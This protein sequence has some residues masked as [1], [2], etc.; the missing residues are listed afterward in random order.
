MVSQVQVGRLTAEMA[1]LRPV[2]RK[3]EMM[4]QGRMKKAMKQAA[5]MIKM[6]RM[7]REVEIR[8]MKTKERMRKERMRVKEPMDEVA[9]RRVRKEMK[10]MRMGK[11]R[12]KVRMVTMR[13][14]RGRGVGE[15][16]PIQMEVMKK[17][18]TKAENK[19]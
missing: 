11:M 13:G 19:E 18:E 7:G 8:V 9:T 10:M 16:E 17:V 15:V 6:M 12:M 2:E 3:K 4:G 5:G 1:R 14:R